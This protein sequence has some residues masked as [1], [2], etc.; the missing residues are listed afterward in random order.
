EGP[1]AILP[2]SDDA[3][4]AHR[5]AVIVTEHGSKT[6]SLMKLSHDDFERA[7][8]ARF[9]K[10]YGRIK[11]IGARAAHPLGFVHAESYIA[12]RMA[13]VA[14]AA[15]GIH[16]VAAQGLNLGLQ[17][18]KALADIV[19]AAHEEKKDIGADAA[20]TAYQRARRF[21]NMAMAAAT[22]ALAR[23]S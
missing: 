11:L 2:M 4:G 6:K 10:R 18:V 22:D 14:D 19:I 21:E 17:D 12:P 15:H 20:L 9:P 3:D 1:F 7:L 16:P 5:S 23:F 13:L 8:A